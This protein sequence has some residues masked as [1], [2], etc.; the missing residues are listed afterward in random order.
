MVCNVKKTVLFQALRYYGLGYKR[1]ATLTGHTRDQVRDLLRTAR[2]WYTRPRD[3]RE[4]GKRQA[5]KL[6]KL[7]RTGPPP[8]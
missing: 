2:D 7:R 6:L 5:R 8:C 3:E 4:A 1:T